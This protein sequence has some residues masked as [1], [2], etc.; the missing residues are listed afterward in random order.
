[1]TENNLIK[2]NAVQEVTKIDGYVAHSW[3]SVT[4]GGEEKF[5]QKSSLDNMLVSMQQGKIIALYKK[6]DKEYIPIY[7][8]GKVQKET[9]DTQDEIRYTRVFLEL[10][11]RKCLV[12]NW[13][14]THRYFSIRPLA[15]DCPDGGSGLEIAISSMKSVQSGKK[16]KALH[17]KPSLADLNFIEKTLQGYGF[18]QNN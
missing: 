7:A 13:L 15:K 14:L 5:H 2:H 16:D 8:E 18:H 3:K 10:E 11:Q 17:W 12:L 1:M 4:W 6:V 9:P